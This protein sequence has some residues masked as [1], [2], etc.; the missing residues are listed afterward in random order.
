ME[1]HGIPA[2]VIVT[3]GF[4]DTARSITHMWG[5]DSYDFLSMP[6]PLSSLTPEEINQQAAVLRPQVLT[7]VIRST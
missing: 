3:D 7:H 2:V 1:R 4:I 5:V 6:H